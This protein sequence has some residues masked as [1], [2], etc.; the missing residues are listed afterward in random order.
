MSVYPQTM[1][2][3][4]D[5][6]AIV[7]TISSDPIYCWQMMVSSTDKGPEDMRYVSG[8][9]FY[10]L[11]GRNNSFAK[12]G[13]PIIQAVNVI[14]H[15]GGGLLFKRLV[16]EDATL[17]NLAILAKVK[18]V[19]TQKTDA[20][21]KPLYTNSAGEE[22]TD[23]SDG[24]EP[25]MIDSCT[26]TYQCESVVGSVNLNEEIETIKTKIFESED[27]SLESVYPLFIIADN[28]RGLSKKRIRISPNYSKSKNK[29]CMYYTLD[30]IEDNAV[31][32]RLSFTLNHDYLDTTY[33]INRALNN[34]TKSSYQIRSHVFEDYF[35][36]FV[37]RV[38]LYTELDS[39]YLYEND[40]FFGFDKSNSDNKIANLNVDLKNG[41]NLSF[42]YGIDLTEGSNGSFGAF[43]FGTQEWEDEAVMF[44]DGTFSNK[45]YDLYNAQ[46]DILVDANYPKPVKQA[47]EALV[48][49]REDF[50]YQRDS[51]LGLTSFEEIQQYN[52]DITK[53]KFICPYGISYNIIDPIKYKEV[54]V[55]I[56]YSL[57][58]IMINHCR[59]G[60][61][62]P[63]AGILHEFT[64]PEAIENTVNFLPSVTPSIDEKKDMYDSGINYASYFD[65]VLT[66]ETFRTSYERDTELSFAHNIL[67]I[68]EVMRAIRNRCPKIRY[69]F[70][71]GDDLK[72][73]Q[74]DVNAVIKK[75]A[76]NF[77]GIQMEYM[78][79]AAMIEEKIYY[80]VIRVVFKNFVNAEK[81]KL[82]AL[83][84]NT[85]LTDAE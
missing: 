47:I 32:E 82:I 37:E 78:A 81:F 2:E 35:D 7:K 42:V 6:S 80:A 11:Y 17:A 12:H 66:V 41:F 15:E 13:Q 30:V 57:A 67:A 45:I 65:N 8:D 75:Y 33:M 4:D 38:A 23:G 60:R 74:D 58:R 31:I 77:S 62:R 84:T 54:P 34:V 46:F 24:N 27:D 69:S 21:G 76:G 79:D 18:K 68:Q 73:Y 51:G 5:Q 49:F 43:P 36:A 25:I 26:I 1:F 9:N 59:Y 72:I 29:E 70:T 40:L 39:D 64:I 50:L 44:F 28:G 10:K 20:D 83:P 48:V 14:E 16:A 53:S 71:S 63:L 19:S 85:V 3:I 22:T 56:G 52:E 55:T 61:N